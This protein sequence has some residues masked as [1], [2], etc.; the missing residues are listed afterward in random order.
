M[1]KL[2]F[3]SDENLRKETEFVIDKALQAKNKSEKKFGRNVIDPFAALFEISGF[4]VGHAEWKSSE[5]V[6]QAQK[7]LQNHVGAFHQRILGHVKDWDDKKTG[8]QVDLSCSSKKI[9]A[10]V[11]NKFSTVTGGNLVNVYDEL[12]ELVTNKASKYK[13]YTAYFV[14]IIPKRAT[15]F[16][17]CFT[18][19]NKKKGTKCA[20]NELVRTIDGASFYELVTGRK[21]ALEELYKALP[22]VIE[23]IFEAKNAKS[24]YKVPDV[25]E[26]TSYFDMAFK[27]VKSKKTTS[28]KSPGKK[29]IPL[30][31]PLL[32]K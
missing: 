28:K 24:T 15:R 7:T 25:T 13:D 32:K 30:R 29:T 26:L 4:G 8:E 9:I 2:E 12:S 16:D 6:R 10:E 21:D 17:E 1:P 20:K 23:E 22:T 5:T 3:I 18:P 14:T 11:K 31:K 19:S 27:Q